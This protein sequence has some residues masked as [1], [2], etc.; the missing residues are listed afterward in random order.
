MCNLYSISSYNH[1]NRLTLRQE[2]PCD[3]FNNIV[4]SHSAFYSQ[5]VE[6]I[7]NRTHFPI[8]NHKKYIIAKEFGT[9]TE[10]NHLFQQHRNPCKGIRETHVDI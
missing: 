7:F 6:Y 1:L 5:L 10:I 9:K 3:E 8:L 4:A 2:R